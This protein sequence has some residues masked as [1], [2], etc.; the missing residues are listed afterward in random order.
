MIAALLLKGFVVGIVIAVPV[1]PVGVLCIRRTILEGRVAGLSSG[2]GAATADAMF[3]VIAGFGLTALSDWL[4][5]YQDWLRIGGAV[6]LFYVGFSAFLHDPAKPRT[7]Q[8]A[9]ETLLANCAS[10]FA[11]TI[12]N[13]VTIL[14]FLAIFAG[15]GLTGREMTMAGVA[16]LVFGVWL[17]S[18]SWWV[19]LA[20]GAGIFRH[21]FTRSHLVW[22]NRGSGG[23]LV[24]CGIGLIGSLF[25]EHCC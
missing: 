18:L 13:P 4:F 3:A 14:S 19:A 6:F 10:T 24:L 1:G 7:P 22:I 25:V 9:P 15:L 21:Q 23:I 16:T 5:G 2:T 17:G 11:L 20:V 12:T 8:Q